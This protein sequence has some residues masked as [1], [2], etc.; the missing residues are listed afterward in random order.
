MSVP[1]LLQALQAAG[2]DDVAWLALADALEEQDDPRAE[3]VRLTAWLRRHPDDGDERTQ[4]Q[5]RLQALLRGGLRPLVPERTIARGV[6]LV[7]VPPGVFWMGARDKE[8]H[9]H[10]DERPRHLVEITRPFWLGAT[11][12]TQR[13][14]ESLMGRNPSSF[15]R[16]STLYAIPHR[17]TRDYP[18]DGVSQEDAAAFCAALS[19]EEG[20]TIRLP[21]EAEWEHACR[22]GMATVF[23]VGDAITSDAA[24]FDGNY[25]YG[26]AEKGPYHYRTGPVGSYPPNAFGLFDMHGQLWEWCSDRYSPGY[27]ARSP[28]ADPKGPRGGGNRVMRGGSWID[29]SWNVRC[30]VRRGTEPLH[31]VGLRVAMDA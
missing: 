17:S 22:A 15:V 12:V 4:K 9:A 3:L 10:A 11:H 27:Y 30:A 31:Y 28:S 1:V 16:G 13:Q 19:A 20:R 2:G 6:R 26:G 21:T 23:H 18:V 29:A 25:P 14:Y 24:N 8:E 5:D 7:L